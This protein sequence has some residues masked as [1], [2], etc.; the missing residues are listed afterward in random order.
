[1]KSTESAASRKSHRPGQAADVETRRNWFQWFVPLLVV[2]L[3]C[4]T[5]L[6][7]LWNDFVNWDDDRNLIDNLSYRGLGWQQL[8]WM[9][10]TFHEG[11]YQP[12]S[13]LTF[14][15]DYLIWGMNPVGYHLTSL[16][17]H[18]ANAVLFYFV[19]RRLL[20]AALPQATSA[21]NW[22]LSVGAGLTAL[23]FSIH[24]LRVE[25]VAWATE[26]RDVL[27]AWFF[28]GAIY[29]YLRS[30]AAEHDQARRRWMTGAIVVYALSLFSKATAMTLP[31][32]LLWL[33]IYPLKRLRL[34]WPV[35]FTPVLRHILSEKLPFFL[36]AILFAVIALFAQQNTG[37]L[38]PV[39]NYFV[40]YRLGQAFYGLYFYLWKTLLPVSLSPLYELP[41][42]FDMWTPVFLAC[43]AAAVVLSALLYLLRQRWPA[44]LACWAYYLVV[45]A[46]VLGVA[47]S[48]PQLVADRYSYLSCLSWALLAGGV[49][50]LCLNPSRDRSD[51]AVRSV[52]VP[53][54]ASAVL[55]ILG[56][57]TWKQSQVWRDSKTLW[58]HAIAVGS[59]SAIARYNLARRSEL[60]GDLPDSIE[61]YRRAISINPTMADA[62]HNLARLLAKQGKP[63]E[64][65]AHYR[66]ALKFK[67]NDAE[68]HN[69]LALLFASKGELEA[70]LAEFRRAMVID[71]KFAKPYFNLGRLFVHGGEL[72]KAIEHFH[73]ALK[74]APDGAEIHAA[75]GDAYVRSGIIDGAVVHFEAAVKLKPEL[76]DAHVALARLLAEQG[77]KDAAA[78]HYRAAVELLKTARSG[79]PAK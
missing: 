60:E 69:N 24:P 19:A 1:M 45:V 54:F 68:T 31:I 10:S 6:P 15:L 42:D 46:P 75:L 2:V 8:S 35:N 70:S 36:L 65:I 53:L 78:R 37:A 77:Q 43:G 4:A 41:Y 25:S 49:F 50:Y 30:H 63:D 47:Q 73:Q 48:G 39:E 14:G 56:V 33:D 34:A 57:L 66:E 71:P 11:H 18:G 23:L 20:G 12:L 51:R 21:E 13:W 44:A 29:F 17:L 40:T 28:L 72:E 26:R 67:P 32:V 58:R 59:D 76:V 22:R 9:F 62:H 79:P 64:A 3:T 52:L 27:S 7:A 61:H 74:L 5:F 55:M 38:R 16:V